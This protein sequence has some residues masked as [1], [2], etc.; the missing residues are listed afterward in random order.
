ML[1][2]L[3]CLTHQIATLSSSD[4]SIGAPVSHAFSTHNQYKI[5]DER[6]ALEILSAEGYSPIE[7]HKGVKS[8]HVEDATD[9]S[10]DSESVVSR[11]HRLL[12]PA[13]AGQPQ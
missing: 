4:R 12:A 13:V 6:V 3:S 5:A 8:L 2:R 11:G 7:I 1:R 9:V 10:S